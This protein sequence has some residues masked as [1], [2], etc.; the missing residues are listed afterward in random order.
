MGATL[1]SF[2]R[3][4]LLIEIPIVQQFGRKKHVNIVDKT[5]LVILLGAIAFYFV[6]GVLSRGT[7]VDDIGY[8]ELLD[9]GKQLYEHGCLCTNTT[10]QYGSFFSYRYDPGDFQYCSNEFRQMGGPYA[11]DYCITAT[12]KLNRLLNATWALT[13]DMVL[14]RQRILSEVENYVAVMTFDVWNVE[15]DTVPISAKTI[16]RALSQGVL[17]GNLTEFNQIV[18]SSYDEF[19]NIEWT[20][21]ILVDRMIASLT[22]DNDKYLAECV[23]RNCHITRPASLA[24]LFMNAA[25]IVGG[26]YVIIKLL[27]FT[28][29]KRIEESHMDELFKKA[30]RRFRNGD[31]SAISDEELEFLQANSPKY[32]QHIELMKHNP[33]YARSISDKDVLALVAQS[34]KPAHTTSFRRDPSSILLSPHGAPGGKPLVAPT[35]VLGQQVQSTFGNSYVVDVTPHYGS[36]P[37]PVYGSG[38]A[39]AYGSGPAPVYGSASASA[40]PYGSGPMGVLPGS[41]TAPGPDNVGGVRFHGSLYS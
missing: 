23:P 29:A 2:A 17:Q 33:D 3:D 9:D 6:V 31:K 1:K 16:Q 34:A 22:L 32:E 12:Y 36:A 21:Q 8:Q 37:A 38:P 40:P 5:M 14:S 13:S 35:P 26:Y 7:S 19:V 20:I 24:S 4:P 27:G 10:I 11:E 28:V 18:D 25:S 39:P 30:V 41:L 15:S